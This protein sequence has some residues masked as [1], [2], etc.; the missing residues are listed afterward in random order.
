MLSLMCDII[1]LLWSDILKDLLE[2]LGFK[3]KTNVIVEA[4]TPAQTKQAIQKR[5]FLFGVVIVV[6]M[7]TIILRLFYLQILQQDSYLD[8]LAR[9]TR[10]YESITTPRGEIKDRNGELIVSNRITKSIIYYPPNFQRQSDKWELAQK[11][12]TDFNTDELIANQSDL[13][14]LVLFLDSDKIKARVSDEDN[15]AYKNG[16][17]NNNQFDRLL[18]S[19]VSEED[20]NQLSSNDIRAYKVYQQMNKP[21]SG[22]MKII[23]NDVPSNEVAF[24]AEHNLDYPGF[25]SFSNWDREYL[26][27]Y[28][29]GGIIGSVS[30]ESQGLNSELVDYYLAK[31]Y[32]LNERV[33]LSGLEQYYED[34]ISGSNTIYDI[35]YTKEGYAQPVELETGSKGNDLVL[36]LDLDLQKYVDNMVKET[37][38]SK[39]DSLYHPYY[40]STYVIVS[41]PK[42]GDILASVAVKTN[43]KGELISNG[44]LNHL[45]AALPGSSIKGAMVYMGLN[46]NAVTPTEQISEAGV[47]IAGT[48]LKQTFTKGLGSTNSITALAYSSNVYMFHVAMRTANANYAYDQ[49]LYGIDEVDFGVMKSYFSKFGLGSKTGIDMPYEEPGYIGKRFVSGLLLD[50][51]IGQFDSYTPMQLTSYINTI[52]NDG[53]RVKLRYMKETLWPNTN[54]VNNTNEVEVL[55][56]LENKKAIGTV[57]AGFRACVTEGLCRGRLNNNPYQI[58]AKTGTAE[59]NFINAE[60]EYVDNA[61]H[62]LAVS[63][64]PFDKPEVSITCVAPKSAYNQALTNVCIDISADIYDY[65]FNNK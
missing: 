1:L 29:L 43:E 37:I 11:F 22:G 55:N 35:K 36:T 41:D 47:K 16:E 63:Y 5:M 34:T 14:D 62:T 30:K 25:E 24:L 15:R 18:K 9:Y 2:R 50:Y 65:Y 56:V 54:I 49:P 38:L 64:A 28:G 6:A 20:R 59:Y 60:G 13:V 44:A 4:I 10:K 42:T 32:S 17:M 52:A 19:L 48:P 26:E 8:K 51:S 31:N 39:K 3:R 57:Q 21:T 45:E 27:S 40:D 12:I 23:L 53:V 58:A 46:E 7:L 33:G 61:P